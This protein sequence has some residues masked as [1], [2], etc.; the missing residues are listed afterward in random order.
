MHPLRCPPLSP[1]PHEGIPR[2][3]L[4]QFTPVIRPSPTVLIPPRAPRPLYFAVLIPRLRPSIRSC[5]IQPKCARLGGRRDFDVL[6]SFLEF[7]QRR[8]FSEPAAS[9]RRR[10]PSSLLRVLRLG[11]MDILGCKTASHSYFHEFRASLS[12]TFASET[13]TCSAFFPL[14]ST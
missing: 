11:D 7:L 14:R 8:N 3:M 10:L 2:G 4:F 1:I 12:A 6:K 5:S 9:K 13:A